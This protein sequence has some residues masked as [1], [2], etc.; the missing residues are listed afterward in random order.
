MSNHFFQVTSEDIENVLRNNLIRIIGYVKSPEKLADILVEDLDLDA[1][2][3][4]AMAAGDAGA[5]LE[6]QTNAVYKE[7]E[8]A[9]V[10]KGVLS[11]E[12]QESGESLTPLRAA[13]QQQRQ[14]SKVAVEH[15]NSP[16]Y[17][18][19]E[20][21]AG[22]FVMEFD[23]MRE[24]NGQAMV[25]LAPESGEMED[26]MSVAI[27]VDNFPGT[28]D[29][30][31]KMILY[32]GGDDATMSVYLRN[33]RFFITPGDDSVSLRSAQLPDGQHGWVVTA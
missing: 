2:T 14:R 21:G 7:I 15:W 30:V 25:S 17:G 19:D 12:A 28:T 32:M 11:P 1:F 24:S 6:G 23:D 33:G 27:E 8:L 22:A 10:A 3:Q 9:L 26:I 5:E 20:S 4:V 13:E 18:G 29:K 16:R 31:Q